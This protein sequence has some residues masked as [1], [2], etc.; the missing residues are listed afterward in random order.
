LHL[1]IDTGMRDLLHWKSILDTYLLTRNYTRC[2]YY[3]VWIDRTPEIMSSGIR[4][5][6]YDFGGRR[7]QDITDLNAILDWMSFS[8]I[9]SQNGGVGVFVWVGDSPSNTQF[10]KSFHVQSDHMLPHALTRYILDSFENTFFAPNWYDLLTD[11][12]KNYIEQRM[13]SLS[14]SDQN[15]L[16]D[17]MRLVNWK[18]IRRET[19]LQF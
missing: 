2:N 12:Q 6:S 19:N 17:G 5:T 11:K 10:I 16:E 9:S 13:Y 14:T 7:L 8:L 4:E 3:A 18:V 15:L 1:G